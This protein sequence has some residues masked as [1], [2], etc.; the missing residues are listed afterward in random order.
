MIFGHGWNRFY[1]R[2]SVFVDTFSV[3]K[4]MQVLDT[5]FDGNYDEHPDIKEELINSEKVLKEKKLEYSGKKE[6][7]T[8]PLFMDAFSFEM[9]FDD[10]SL[11]SFNWKVSRFS[12]LS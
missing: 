12:R 7:K 11:K 8:V 6:S 4:N 1:E 5:I 9:K 2:D 10:I 3:D